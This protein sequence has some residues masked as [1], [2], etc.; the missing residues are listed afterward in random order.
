MDN[1]H[2]IRLTM[3][4]PESVGAESKQFEKDRKVSIRD[5]AYICQ[6]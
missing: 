3:N 4:I 2:I 5:S 6:K 1:S